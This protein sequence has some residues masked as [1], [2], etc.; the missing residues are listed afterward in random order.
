M[1]ARDYLLSGWL[2]YPY[3]TISFSVDWL[4]P[5]P[6]GLIDA[7]KLWARSPTPAYQQMGVGWEWVRPWLGA[8]LR[9]WVF[10]LVMCMLIAAVAMLVISHLSILLLQ[11]L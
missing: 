5:D 8:N 3:K 1:A 6:Q 7:T 2:M 9:T 10:L 4:A 11:T